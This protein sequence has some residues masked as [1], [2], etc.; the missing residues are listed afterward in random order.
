MVRKLTQK[1]P[2]THFCYDFS[3]FAL[4][5]SSELWICCHKRE[6]ISD[7]FWLHDHRTLIRRTLISDHMMTLQSYMWSKRPGWLRL[8]LASQK[9]RGY[10]SWSVTC[11]GQGQVM[12]CVIEYNLVALVT[13]RGQQ[14]QIICNQEDLFVSASFFFLWNFSVVLN[15]LFQTDPQNPDAPFTFGGGRGQWLKDIFIFTIPV[16]KY[17]SVADPGFPRGGAPTYYL[18]NF[19]LKTAWNERNWT[20]SATCLTTAAWIHQCELGSKNKNKI[21]PAAN[22]VGSR[23]N[24]TQDHNQV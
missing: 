15:D 16:V 4:T 18:A 2:K 8:R 1:Y 9:G 5:D 14:V 12:H 10:D 13:L 20:K 17:E 22:R 11:W 21:L 19:L 24:F 6:A 7:S 3:I 23:Y